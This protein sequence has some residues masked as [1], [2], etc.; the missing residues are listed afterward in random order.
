MTS[1]CK[2]V[3]LNKSELIM[4][5]TIVLFDMDGTLTKPREEFESFLLPTLT[6]L[7]EKAEI[8]IVSGSDYNYICEQMGRI[9]K[10]SHIRYKTH[11]LPCNGTKH[12]TPPKSNVDDYE[13]D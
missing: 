6:D 11:L 7:A 1:I 2:R 9:L 13:L 8:G 5:K 3:I 10:R 4:T 12:Y